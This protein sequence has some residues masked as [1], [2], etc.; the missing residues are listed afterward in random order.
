[1]KIWIAILVSLEICSVRGFAV[2]GL[3]NG[4]RSQPMGMIV[5][6]SARD[7]AIPVARQNTFTL[8]LPVRFQWFNNS[9]YCGETSLISAG[10]YYGQYISQFLA[11]EIAAGGNPN[12]QSDTQLLLGLNDNIAAE[13][14]HLNFVQWS[15]IVNTN[16]F[17]TWVKAYVLNGFPVTI[18]VYTNEC[19]FYDDCTATAGQ[20]EYDHIVPVIGIQSSQPLTPPP[21]VPPP[22]PAFLETDQIT[23]S[24]NGIQ[25]PVDNPTNPPNLPNPMDPYYFTYTFAGIQTNR[26]QANSPS[27]QWYSLTNDADT[28]AIAILGV[29]DLDGDTIPVRVDTNV[30]YEF[31]EIVDGSN[32]MPA[33]MPLTLTVTV[34]IPNTSLAYNLYRYNNLTL[35][36]ESMFNANAGHAVQ[37][38]LIPAHSGSTFVI[39]QNIM[40]NE[41]AAYRAVSTTAP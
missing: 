12:P 11:R 8:N 26:A 14:M 21:P 9:G 18:G 24:D 28:F 32:V 17:L 22:F 31:P 7:Q 13:M 35:V 36:P 6:N 27:G 2:P 19:L 20:S 33:P 15:P 16:E 4:H 3:L 38:W 41:V 10:L 30:N 23:F 29:K 39:T 1:M 25:G 40:S 37:Q 34:T 5:R